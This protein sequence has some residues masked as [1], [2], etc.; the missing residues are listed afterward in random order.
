MSEDIVK[1][2]T[3]FPQVGKSPRESIALWKYEV[4]DYA[5]SLTGTGYEELGLIGAVLPPAQYALISA[6][7][8]AFIPD[9][10]I[11]QGTAV[12]REVWKLN[13]ESRGKQQR[14]IAKLKAFMVRPIA[15]E[16]KTP[17]NEPFPIRMA[18]RTCSWIY[19]SMVQ[20]HG[21]LNPQE[22]Q[23][24]RSKLDS[25]LN[26]TTSTFA[27]HLSLH[28]QIHNLL[29]ENLQPI[30][31]SVKVEKLRVSIQDCQVFQGAIAAHSRSF[32][33]VADQTF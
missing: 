8:F 29:E 21:I 17:M 24:T 12:E 1:Q 28:L 22:L 2:A 13:F 7:P 9:P 4:L 5:G 25:Q 32:P 27:T 15:E 19:N 10:G 26:L 20:E 31:D 3:V 16:F 30:T 6:N 23:Q 33:R 11:M 14:N 18:N